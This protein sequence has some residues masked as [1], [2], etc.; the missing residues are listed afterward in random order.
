M[1]SLTTLFIFRPKLTF[2]HRARSVHTRSKSL[3]ACR[4]RER[5]HGKLTTA[6][7]DYRQDRRAA[8]YML[9][10][11]LREDQL[12]FSETRSPCDSTQSRKA[13]RNTVLR[14]TMAC[15]EQRGRQCRI[16]DASIDPYIRNTMLS[17]LSCSLC[18]NPP[19]ATQ[20]MPH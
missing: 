13:A 9:M 6:P 8:T 19:M 20:G 12:F 5:C 10:V 15:S 18:R 14:T 4:Q 16:R 1:R 17:H 7:N 2:L 3:S 11:R